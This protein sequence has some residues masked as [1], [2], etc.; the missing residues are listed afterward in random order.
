[1]AGEGAAF[2]AV[3]WEAEA[4]SAFDAVWWEAEAASAFDEVWWEAEATS[5]FDAGWGRAYA[6][7]RRPMST[8]MDRGDVNFMMSRKRFG[9]V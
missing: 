5:A 9:G 7:V 4:A 2:D 1:V 8:S 3:W 6:T